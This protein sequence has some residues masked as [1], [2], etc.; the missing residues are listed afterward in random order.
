MGTLAHPETESAVLG[1]C[2]SCPVRELGRS[3]ARTKELG[4]IVAQIC[5]QEDIGGGLPNAALEPENF[6]RES[7]RMARQL[8]ARTR[9]G[10][11]HK[12]EAR[13]VVSCVMR[14]SCAGTIN[15]ERIE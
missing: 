11:S 10:F 5:D 14:S 9:I 7:Y 8:G 2:L 6:E 4:A 15:N 13:A 3:S 1:M 12:D